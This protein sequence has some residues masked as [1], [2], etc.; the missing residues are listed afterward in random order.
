MSD[1]TPPGSARDHLYAHSAQSPASDRTLEVVSSEGPDRHAPATEVDQA[2]AAGVVI[3][4]DRGYPLI[5]DR[6]LY[7]ELVKQAIARTVDE[8]DVKVAERAAEKKANRGGKG[9]RP[10]DPV[11]D[12]QREE[13]HQLRE[14]SERAHG[15]NLDLGAGLLTGLATVDPSDMDVARAFVYGLLGADYDSSPYT[16]TGS[17]W[18]A[19][20]CWESAW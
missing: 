12:A 14:L 20:Q 15:V 9:E 1:C 7:R 18:C 10:A 19:W 11:A 2:R 17:A 16:Q 5:V 6:A 4:F 3:E 13:Q 8:L